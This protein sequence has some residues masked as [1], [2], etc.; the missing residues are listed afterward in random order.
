[1]YTS[2]RRTA[3]KNIP[4][5]KHKTLEDTMK[6]DDLKYLSV[7]LP[8]DILKEKWSGNF[9]RAR[10]IINRRMHEENI[11]YSLKCRLELELN[12]LNLLEQCYTLTKIE[13][14]EVVRKRIPDMSE[15]EFDELQLDGKIDWIYLNGET[16]YLSSFCGTLCK[17]YPEL[18][19][20]VIGGDCRDYRVLDELIDNLEDGEET[21]CHIHIKQKM[22]IAAETLEAGKLLK[23]HIPLPQE[24]EYVRNLQVINIT[25]EPTKLPD[26]KEKQPSVYFERTSEYQEYTLEYSLDNV[27][28]YVDLKKVDLKRVN[29]AVYPKDVLVYTK[30]Q[31]PHIQFTPYL[32]A[33]A[34]EIKGEETNPLIVARKFYDYITTKIQYRFV[35]EYASIDN[36]SEYCGINGKGDCGVQALLFIAL[37]RISG[38][39]AKWESG[40]DAK[41]ND[42]GEHDWAMFYIPTLG[43]LYADLSYGGS[44]YIR[45]AYKRWDY[46][47]GNIDPYRIPINSEFQAELLPHKLYWRIDPYDN[48]CGEAECESHGFTGNDISYSYEEIDIHRID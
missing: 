12:N 20:R 30:E 25:P 45:G 6:Y 10:K 41:P 5:K 26:G 14:L 7:P 1:M 29:E 35:R 2:K 47:F 9:E 40:L 36:I 24:N 31:L 8:E 34:D 16:K 17:V 3:E 11:P 37:C 48:Q 18:W 28:K 21:A 22:K 33:L 44:S 42:V 23:V 46:Y 4:E 39:P 38:I 43:W 27:R 13:A 32:K 19:P 15:E